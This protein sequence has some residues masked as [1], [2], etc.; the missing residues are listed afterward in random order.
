[1]DAR[2]IGLEPAND[3]EAIFVPQHAGRSGEEEVAP[4][5]QVGM[6]VI[7]VRGID[8]VP[9]F[10]SVEQLEKT[11]PDVSYARLPVAALQR[12]VG[13]GLGVVVNPFGD[14]TR[15]LPAPEVAALPHPARTDRTLVPA[16]TE[17]SIGAPEREEPELYAAVGAFCADEPSIGAAYRALVAQGEDPGAG[18]LIIGLLTDPGVGREAVMRAAEERLRPPEG[19]VFALA[20]LDPDALSA[21]GRFMVGQTTPIYVRPA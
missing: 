12:M 10:S 15:L 19:V 14:L 17:L 1:M 4:G 9:V 6:R 2:R 20:V 13:E 11:I 16:S 3:L 8:A 21:I 7:E 5:D 18:R